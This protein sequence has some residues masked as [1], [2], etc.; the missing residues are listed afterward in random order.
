[1]L[2]SLVIDIFS[3]INSI[4]IIVIIS[5]CCNTIIWQVCRKPF[6]PIVLN[7]NLYV[8]NAFKQHKKQITYLKRSIELPFNYK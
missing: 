2:L 3:S 5:S 7:E 8:S 1:M 4:C 6:H